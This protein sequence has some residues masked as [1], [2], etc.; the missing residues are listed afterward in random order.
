VYVDEGGSF[1]LDAGMFLQREIVEYY[2]NLL[3][4]Y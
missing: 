3:I 2:T 1:H 4:N